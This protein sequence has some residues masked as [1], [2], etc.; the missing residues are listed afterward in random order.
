MADQQAYLREIT[1]QIQDPLPEERAEEAA[2]LWQTAG[3]TRP[4]N[5]PVAD[6]MQALR[7]PA[8]T[9]LWVEDPGGSASS[10]AGTALVGE[11]GHRGWVYYVAVD[12]ALRGRGIGAQLIRAAEQWLEGRGVR[13]LMLMV[14]AEN[15]AVQEFYRGLGYEPQDVMTMGRWLRD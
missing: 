12:E 4:W 3:L 7:S 6:C 1:V 13:K 10:V 14:R 8:S 9:V 11:D 15:H 5:D 2:A